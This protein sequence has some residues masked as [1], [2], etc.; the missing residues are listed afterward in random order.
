MSEPANDTI[1]RLAKAG[2]PVRLDGRGRAGL[3]RAGLVRSVG[4]GKTVTGIDACGT[5][6]PAAASL[7]RFGMTTEA[8][9]R[10][11]QDRLRDRWGR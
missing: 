5:S 8:V 3:A 1:P 11:A 2:R 6:G 4:R 7:P 10:P 9:D